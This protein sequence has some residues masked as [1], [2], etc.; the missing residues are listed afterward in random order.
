M[1]R[2][3]DPEPVLQICT[4]LRRVKDADEGMDADLVAC[5]EERRSLASRVGSLSR[6][7]GGGGRFDTHSKIYL[8]LQ[9]LSV[10]YVVFFFFLAI[11]SISEGGHL[12]KSEGR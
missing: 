10:H 7:A 3:L 2:F 11:S 6:V 1:E 12:E 9:R 4:P 8:T 5:R